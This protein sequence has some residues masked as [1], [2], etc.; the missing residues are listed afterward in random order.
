M[1]LL[2]LP[3]VGAPTPVLVLAAVRVGL[4]EVL[5]L[6]LGALLL[7]ILV[8][9]RLPTEVLPVVSIH[10]DVTG[11]LGVAI[12][13]PDGLEV[14]YVKVGRVVVTTLSNRGSSSLA[15]LVEEVN[16]DFLF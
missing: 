16:R 3:P 15:K 1:V 9:V 4:D 6:P 14:E 7:I 2:L 12:G 5:G 10:A 13:A 8:E 11:V